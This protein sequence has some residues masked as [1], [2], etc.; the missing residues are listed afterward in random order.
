MNG[1]L[2]PQTGAKPDTISKI[3]T[4]SF[5]PELFSPPNATNDERP[6]NECCVCSEEYTSATPMKRTPCGHYFHTECLEKW[7]KVARTCPLCRLDLE[8]AVEDPE[9]QPGDA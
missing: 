4:V 3:E 1:W 6:P 9:S 5:D 8:D 2:S 7:L